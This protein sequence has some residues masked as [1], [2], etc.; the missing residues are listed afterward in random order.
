MFPSLVKSGEGFSKF[1]F[2]QETRKRIKLPSGGFVTIRKLSPMDTLSVGFIPQAFPESEAKRRRGE[3]T[4]PSAEEIAQGIKLSIIALT[5]CASRITVKDG[6]KLRI[7][8]KELDE[9]GPDEITVG[10]LDQ[11]DASAIVQSVNELSALTKEATL[12]VK[13]FSEIEKATD[14]SPQAGEAVSQAAQ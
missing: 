6:R 13:P 7:V 4:G 5:R 2:M 3:S 10:E 8:D 14:S 12:A 11:D 1:V 9:C